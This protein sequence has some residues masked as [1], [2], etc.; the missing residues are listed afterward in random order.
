MNRIIGAELACPSCGGLDINVGN[1][2]GEWDLLTELGSNPESG[3]SEVDTRYS[4]YR[5][6]R[7]ENVY[8]FHNDGVL[9]MGHMNK[10]EDDFTC[11]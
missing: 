3:P 10:E 11:W 8:H 5:C 1:P 7:C 2:G 6:R 9:H 4:C